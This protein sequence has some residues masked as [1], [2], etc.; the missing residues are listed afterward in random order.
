M[1]TEAADEARTALTIFFEAERGLLARFVANGM[2]RA[3]Y[4][5]SL[6]GLRDRLCEAS[7]LGIV[8]LS[9]AEELLEY[10]GVYLA[11]DLRKRVDRLRDEAEPL[12]Q[13][14]LNE[15]RTANTE[16]TTFAVLDAIAAFVVPPLPSI[17]SE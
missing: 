8:V 17:P 5:T 1:T 12:Y 6:Q 9:R 2:T 15:F 16:R 4:L 11:A 7:Y 14:W 13:V 3:T 10:P